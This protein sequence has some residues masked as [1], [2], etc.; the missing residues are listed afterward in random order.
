MQVNCPQCQA[1]IG[2]DDIDL[3]LRIGKCRNCSQ[4]VNIADQLAG[5]A[6]PT[7]SEE[8]V[9]IAEDPPIVP[10]PASLSVQEDGETLVITKRWFH[11]AAFFL[12]FFCIA[13]DAFLF[14]WYAMALGGFGKFGG[15][16]PPDLFRWLFLV[17]P[18][19]HVAVGVG[20]TYVC[21]ATFLNRSTL[22]V[23]D[24][25]LSLRHGPMFWPGQFVLPVDDI[26]Q[27]YVKPVL[28]RVRYHEV[29]FHSGVTTVNG[30]GQL[31]AVL[32]SGGERRLWGNE[33]DPGIVRYLETRL[34]EFLGIENRPVA[35]EQR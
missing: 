18:L 15:E 35:G 1:A 7:A 32:K 8:T 17:F 4:V 12:L 26:E 30:P 31:M 24:G 29:G 2:M 13:W 28:G 16:G 23:Q 9:S 27:F 11:P 21:V 10:R 20:L 19:G 3:G 22:T 34:E 25:F 5:L 6:A 33:M 14:V